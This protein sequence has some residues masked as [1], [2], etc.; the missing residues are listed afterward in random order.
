MVAT[1][2]PV[3]GG[4]LDEAAA[5]TYADWFA[6]LAD[7]TR[8][9]VLHTVATAGDGLPIGELA[10]RVGIAQ[11]TCSHHVKLLAEAGFVLLTKAGTSTIVRVN[12]ACCTGLPHAADVVMGTLDTLPCCPADVPSDVDLRP[13]ADEDWPVVADIYGQGIETRNATFATEVPEREELERKWLD[14]HRH[15]AMVDG[16]V[17]GWAALVGVSDRECYAGVAETQVYVGE[18]FRGRGVGVALID[19]L[20]RTADAGDLW[21]LQASIFPENRASLRLH[22]SAGFRTV[23][24]RDRIAKLDGEWRDTVL[25]ERR[26]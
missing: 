8:V 20:V 6:T 25:L 5:I 1:P 21:T 4:G 19:R 7:S 12:E 14:G 24:V 3:I 17:A 16:E 22:H 18:G 15:V 10:K 9:R 11:P 26:R 2:L 23:G 13:M